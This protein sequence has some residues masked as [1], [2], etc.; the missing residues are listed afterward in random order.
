MAL[1]ILFLTIATCGILALMPID[2]TFP[3][4][5][6]SGTAAA[7]GIAPINSVG[8]L[9]GFAGSMI[10]GMAKEM[11]GNINN[12]TYALGV[13][14]LVSCVLI[15]FIP[16][17]VL[18]P[19]ASR[20]VLRSPRRCGVF[21]SR[22]PGSG[23]DRQRVGGSKRSPPSRRCETGRRSWRVHPGPD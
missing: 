15:A 4:Q 23:R 2:W 17:D 7:A 14:L 5:I 16:R 8:N 10:T 12:G 22:R 18:Q 9:F 1:S 11:T 13:C 19:P 20:Q 3:G 21:A 6:L